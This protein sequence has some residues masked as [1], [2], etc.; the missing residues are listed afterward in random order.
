MGYFIPG[1]TTM[2]TDYCPEIYYDC[3]IYLIGSFVIVL[4]GIGWIIKGLVTLAKRKKLT[5]KERI[6]KSD[7]E[8]DEKIKELEKRMKSIYFYKN[9]L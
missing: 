9:W 3:G 4:I 5:N 1:L 8:K 2:G 7:I 6:Q